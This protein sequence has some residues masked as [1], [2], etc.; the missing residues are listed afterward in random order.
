MRLPIHLK[1]QQK[2]SLEPSARRMSKRPLHGE[3]LDVEAVEHAAAQ[4]GRD[5]HVGETAA[6][7]QPD[8][9]SEDVRVSGEQKRY[10]L[11]GNHISRRRRG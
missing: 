11:H 1:A 10:L 2:A 3:A 5:R 9:S 8:D 7:E 6:R 4:V